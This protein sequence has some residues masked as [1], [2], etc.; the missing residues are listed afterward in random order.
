[1]VTKYSNDAYLAKDS[2]NFHLAPFDITL[3]SLLRQIYLLRT[4]AKNCDR[5]NEPRNSPPG[6]AVRGSQ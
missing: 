2:V 1:M 4:L 3:A 6:P 5:L